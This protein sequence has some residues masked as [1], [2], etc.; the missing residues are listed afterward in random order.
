M[1]GAQVITRSA[2]PHAISN[3]DLQV[4]LRRMDYGDMIGYYNASV[5]T[6]G[7]KLSEFEENHRLAPSQQSAE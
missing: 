1:H 5:P 4:V 2:P 3:I 6:A 7:G